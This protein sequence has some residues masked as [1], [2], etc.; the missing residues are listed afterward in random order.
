MI[1]LSCELLQNTGIV[2]GC[3]SS[4]IDLLTTFNIRKTMTTLTVNF[5]SNT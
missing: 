2:I 4:I 5:T 1:M 3:E